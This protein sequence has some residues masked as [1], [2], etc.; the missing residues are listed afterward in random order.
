MRSPIGTRGDGPPAYVKT[1]EF[2]T[3]RQNLTRLVRQGVLDRVARGVYRV[4]DAP[5]TENYSLA[6]VAAAAPSVVICL[7]TALRFHEVGTQLPSEV[8]VAVE[9]GTRPPSLRNPKLRIATFSGKSFH[10]GI[11]LHRLESVDV[12]IY[13]I[14]KTIADVFKFRNKVGLDV[15]IEALRDAWQR[16]LVTIDELD[17]YARV[18]RVHRVMSPYVEALVG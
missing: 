12:R 6:V 18:C 11:E 9:R 13:G 2:G 17:H 10:E 1:D 8:W 7:L 3:H 16:R 15:A 5:L 4:T 14:A